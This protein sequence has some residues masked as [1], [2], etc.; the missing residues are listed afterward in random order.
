[1]DAVLVAA[2]LCLWLLQDHFV[3]GIVGEKRI[4]RLELRRCRRRTRS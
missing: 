1:M 3:Q 4:L 2:R